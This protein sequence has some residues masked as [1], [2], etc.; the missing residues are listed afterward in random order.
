MTTEFHLLFVNTPRGP[1]P[2]SLSRQFEATC[3]VENRTVDI[4]RNVSRPL[5]LA[6]DI[7]V[8]SFHTL[9]GINGSGK[10]QLLMDIR[11]T[12]STGAKRRPLGVFY[13]SD[14]E[15]KVYQGSLL[16]GWTVTLDGEPVRRIKAAPEASSIFYTTSPFEFARRR[17]Y[18]S[19]NAL[20]ASPEIGQSTMFDA[21][22][23]LRAADSLPE[24]V[25]ERTKI[26]ITLKVMTVDQIANYIASTLKLRSRSSYNVS[27]VS[28]PP[29]PA[30]SGRHFA[31]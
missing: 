28:D 18:L 31:G 13:F 30:C 14:D 16:G 1:V 29:N 24:T 4:R 3:D 23:L 5:G 15:F 11:Q 9:Y 25:R 7:G 12:F 21:L 27:I 19:S 22:G 6:T 17:R 26:R 8:A 20:D 10:T 2:I